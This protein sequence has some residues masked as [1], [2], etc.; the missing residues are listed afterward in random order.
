MTLAHV[1]VFLCL[2]QMAF[3]LLLITILLTEAYIL[4]GCLKWSITPPVV[5]EAFWRWGHL[6][7]ETWPA[8]GDNHDSVYKCGFK[9]DWESLQRLAKLEWI[10]VGYLLSNSPTWPDRTGKQEEGGN[11]FWPIFGHLLGSGPSI[12]SG[13]MTCSLW[14]EVPIKRQPN[15]VQRRVGLDVPPMQK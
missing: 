11:L 13:G 14:T 2:I 6:L 1:P 5:S 9:L 4:A 10:F 8:P 15:V 12:L 3:L 7:C